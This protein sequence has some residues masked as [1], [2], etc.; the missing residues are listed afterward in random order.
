MVGVLVSLFTRPVSDEKLESFYSLTRT[1]IHEDEELSE[2]CTLPEGVSAA[3][4]NNI[5]TISGL[6]IQKPSLIGISGFL[7]SWAVVGLIIYAFV[8]ISR[9]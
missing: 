9:A 2:P 5:F 7:I 8:L 6:E 3:P 1:P 4:R